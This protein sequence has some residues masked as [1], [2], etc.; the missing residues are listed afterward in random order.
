MMWEST[1]S[2]V[3]T[4]GRETTKSMVRGERRKSESRFRARETLLEVRLVAFF[5]A[6]ALRSFALRALAGTFLEARFRA[7]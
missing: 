3:R 6:R 5:T 1:K 4:M 2:R 7:G